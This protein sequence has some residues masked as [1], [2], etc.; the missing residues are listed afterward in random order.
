[1][2]D[3]FPTIAGLALPKQYLA[4]CLDPE[5]GHHA[6]LL[7]GPEGIG[8]LALALAYVKRLV[9]PVDASAGLFGEAVAPTTGYDP[10]ST[11]VHLARI[12]SHPD[13]IVFSRS[14][15]LLADEARGLLDRLATSPQ[16]AP[17]K[18][19]ILDGAEQF[20]PTVANLLLKSLEEPPPWGQFLLLTTAPD[21]LLPTIRS[22]TLPVPCREAGADEIAGALRLFFPPRVAEDLIALIPLVGGRVGD[23]LRLGLLPKFSAW[24]DDLRG[25][26]WR[27]AGA[28]PAHLFE[29][30]T[31]LG[32]L[33]TAWEKLY[34]SETLPIGADL[35]E[36]A[37]WRSDQDH[38]PAFVN[39][40]PESEPPP[41]TVRQRLFL[42]LAGR[43]AIAAFHGDVAWQTDRMANLM[44][45]LRRAARRLEYN[46]NWSLV[47]EGIVLETMGYDCGVGVS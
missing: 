11:D 30:E 9:G 32:A 12:G 34:T 28:R 42:T 16:R 39:W 4:R 18:V 5:G 2:G 45:G 3:P 23:L 36:L 43:L 44:E 17:R 7:H 13:I 41:A 1:M 19:V 38:A 37:S 33:F 14:R 20:N 24:C 27:V 15:E 22:R 26:L 40:F 35:A 10:V 29:L 8:K 46:A 47:L 25:C 31:D 21:Q 6:L